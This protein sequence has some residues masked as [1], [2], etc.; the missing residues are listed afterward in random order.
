MEDEDMKTAMERLI[1]L[2]K[3]QKERGSKLGKI[4]TS[5]FKV[6]CLANVEKAARVTLTRQ[7][8]ENLGDT[9]EFVLLKLLEG[10]EDGTTFCR[11]AD[12]AESCRMPEAETAKILGDLLAAGG[13]KTI[14]M[15]TPSGIGKEPLYA[16]NVEDPAGG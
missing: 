10:N 9:H 7:V 11:V 6:V 16:P 14:P 3:G 8:V 13:V 4:D 2:E 15:P 5:G 12:I 1:E